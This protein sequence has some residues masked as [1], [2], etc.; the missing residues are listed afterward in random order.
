MVNPFVTETL[1][2]TEGVIR[3]DQRVAVAPASLTD[4]QLDAVAAG[5]N[6]QP[7]PPRHEEFELR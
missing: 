3:L 7:L 1:R 2:S 4:A 5:L 6:P